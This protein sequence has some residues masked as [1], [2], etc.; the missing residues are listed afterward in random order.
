MVKGEIERDRNA[1]GRVGEY[2]TA[3]E[4]A[5]EDKLCSEQVQKKEKK[6][7]TKRLGREKVMRE[8]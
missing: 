3:H 4:G 5:E 7:K 2:L 8:T 6:T 1:R